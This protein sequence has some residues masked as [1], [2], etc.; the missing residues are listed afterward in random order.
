MT[1]RI[2]GLLISLFF[3]V[4]VIRSRTSP[5]ARVCVAGVGSTEADSD[6][7]GVVTSNEVHGG[8][9]LVDVAMLCF[10]MQFT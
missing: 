3:L 8:Y 6:K 1:R 10:T 5:A 9:G 7:D 2:L 4:G